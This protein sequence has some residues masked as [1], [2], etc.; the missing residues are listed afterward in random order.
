MLNQIQF[1]HGSVLP[2]MPL[3]L[4]IGSHISLFSKHHPLE[5]KAQ[6]EDYKQSC[7]ISCFK[8]CDH[9]ANSEKENIL[10]T[11]HST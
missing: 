7:H 1:L 8:K 6:H 2:A 3:L 10:I 5:R 9:A 4:Q 11:K